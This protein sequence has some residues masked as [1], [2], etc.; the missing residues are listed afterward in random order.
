MDMV[1]ISPCVS[2]A[3]TIASTATV[4]MSSAAVSSRASLSSFF[5]SSHEL[6]HRVKEFIDLLSSVFSKLPAFF[7]GMFNTPVTSA[8]RM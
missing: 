8:R 4:F 6:S 3:S 2:A 7:G 5:D 1:F